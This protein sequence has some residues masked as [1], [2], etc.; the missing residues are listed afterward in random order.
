MTNFKVFS[1]LKQE[2][3]ITQISKEIGLSI[4]RT[5]EIVKK[6]RDQN[7]VKR[8]K[9]GKFI[10]SDNPKV[11]YL[12]KIEN[13]FNLDVI[14][15]KNSEKILLQLLKPKRFNELEIKTEL[16]SATLYKNIRMLM[17]VGA[18]AKTEERFLVNE[19]ENELREY[20]KLRAGEEI[21]EEPAS[22]VVWSSKDEKLKKSGLN[23]SG[24][25]TA[26]SLF[27]RYGIECAP[28]TNYFYYPKK[29]LGIEEIFVHALAFSELKS[30]M[31]LSIL[32]YLK[33]KNKADNS[34]IKDLSKKFNV[35]EL[36]LDVLSFLDDA[37]VKNQDRFPSKA[38]F[39]EKAKLYGIELK[40]RFNFGIVIELFEAIGKE[41]EK[42]LKIFII[43][44]G[45]MMIKGLK[46]LTKDVDIVAVSDS[47][48]NYFIGKIKS[49]G[50]KQPRE[51]E[52][53]YQ[54]LD[55]LIFEKEGFPRIDIFNQRVCRAIKL[56]KEIAK[57]AELYRKFGNL[58][59]M[60]LSNDDLFLLKSITDREGDFEDAKILARRGVDW[61]RVL[62]EIFLQE[63]L[64]KRYFSFSVLDT[65]EILS[66][67]EEMKIPI[68]RDL[69]RHCT[70]LA[71]L[72]CL[73]DSKTLKELK[74][75][76]KIP[77][78][79]LSNLLKGLEKSGNIKVDR[80][81]IPHK[82][83]LKK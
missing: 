12:K 34:R 8:L 33:N 30:E 27:S 28:K 13:K 42:P 39:E 3:T 49:I 35:L 83:Y 56:S 58:F 69:R 23:I 51:I 10:L 80:K 31:N 4:N 46:P 71:V 17:S 52:P 79:E 81:Q 66:E 29:D 26:F 38:D 1:K 16:T 53:A 6:L 59:V 65:L 48:F 61:K 22:I 60:L 67:T 75:D 78:Y 37:E 55:A 62:N 36:W 63:K 44:G 64:T 18:V 15:S 47:D 24:T 57:N 45:N 25:A 41:I 73:K 7:L 54:K 40:K 72:L 76:I 32:F 2:K 9:N 68:L 11:S 50:F 43:G 82:Y 70:K 20:L 77:T 5:S 74:D 14:L 19:K 21:N